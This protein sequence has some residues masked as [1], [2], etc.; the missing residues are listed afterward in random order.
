[1]FVQ[2]IVTATAKVLEVSFR[3]L[4][5]KAGYCKLSCTQYC[6]PKL[7][8]LGFTHRSFSNCV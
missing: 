5:P 1:M 7:S 2:N 3:R 8:R 6:R 4:Y